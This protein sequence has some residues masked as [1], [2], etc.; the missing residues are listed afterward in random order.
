M[1]KQFENLSKIFFKK[2]F[3]SFNTNDR[4]KYFINLQ[5]NKLFKSELIYNISYNKLITIRNYLNNALKKSEF[6]FQIIKL[7]RRYYLLKK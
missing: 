2:S 3:N 6:D 7:T 5:F 4:I 1:F